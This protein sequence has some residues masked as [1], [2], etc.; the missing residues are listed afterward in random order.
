MKEWNPQSANTKILKIML[1]RAIAILAG[2]FLLVCLNIYQ[3]L[4]GFKLVSKSV[5]TCSKQIHKF[6]I[7]IAVISKIKQPRW[8]TNQKKV[9]CQNEGLFHDLLVVTFADTSAQPYTMMVKLKDT[10]V[11]NVAVTG[12]G[13]SKNETSFA[14]F[15]LEL[16]W[17]VC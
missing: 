6:A 17:G 9:L 10:I 14:K 4:W 5:R 12:S 3:P 2:Y 15:E 13:R 1:N 8:T 11:A 16:H 7:H